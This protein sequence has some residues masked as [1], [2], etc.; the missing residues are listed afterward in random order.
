MTAALDVNR[1]VWGDRKYCTRL[2]GGKNSGVIG[3]IL[4]RSAENICTLGLAGVWPNT[5]TN[6]RLHKYTM[7]KYLIAGRLQ[8]LT[9]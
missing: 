4:L 3:V 6:F 8:Y 1:S 9:F 2:Q 7:T 5:A